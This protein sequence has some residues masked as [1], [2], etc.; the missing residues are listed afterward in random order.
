MSNVERIVLIVILG[1][2]VGAFILV[3][4]LWTRSL[5][6]VRIRIDDDPTEEI[7]VGPEM[8]IGL[9]ARAPEGGWAEQ[10][11]LRG[12]GHDA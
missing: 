6:K 5:M 9:A 7:Y 4:Y 2:T 10:M 11:R 3:P 1:S 12:N 8:Q